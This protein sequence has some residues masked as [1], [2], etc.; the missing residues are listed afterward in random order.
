VHRPPDREYLAC[1]PVE[2]GVSVASGTVEFLARTPPFDEL[3][4]ALVARLAGR[5]EGV[6]VPIRGTVWAPGDAITHVVVVRR[7]AVKVWAGDHE[8][9]WVTLGL[10][11]RGSVLCEQGVLEADAAHADAAS[12]FDES[13]VVRLPVE[14]VRTAASVSAP[15]A[16]GLGALA[17]RRAQ[18][19]ERRLGLL[20]HRS[21]H[22]R[23]AALFLAL[24]SDF[25]VR[26]SRGVI[27]NLKLTHRELA[28]LIGVTRETVSVTMQE[29]RR[30][31][32]VAADGKRPVL[33]DERRLQQLA[34]GED[35]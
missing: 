15:F 14:L 30:Q 32:L 21:A 19:L 23:L 35:P 3:P 24:S 12:A 2:K 25:G 4:A 6:E 9:R 34:A 26:D 18:R 28:A 8:A 16:L 29:L 10:Y 22:A 13:A 31:G 11:G 20:L 17:A 27:I 7:G 5:A 33:L 1:G